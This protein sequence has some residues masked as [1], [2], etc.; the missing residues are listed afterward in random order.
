M[1]LGVTVRPGPSASQRG[2]LR[3]PRSAGAGFSL[4]EGLIATALLLTLAIGVLPLFTRSMINNEGGSDFTQITNAAKARAEELFQLPFDSPVLAVT[5]GTET[6]LEEYFSQND[7]IWKAGTDADA[8]ADGDLAL[9]R[10]TTTIRQFNINDLTT[11]L[12]AA[13]PPGTV[14]IREI[15]VLAQSTRAGSPLGPGKQHVVRVLKSQ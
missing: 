8:T 15:T 10:R 13:A 6:V 12:D 9:F 3:R 1:E 14:Q 7:K 2:G 4:I 5:A 11:P